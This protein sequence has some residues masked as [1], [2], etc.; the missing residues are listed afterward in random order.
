MKAMKMPELKAE[1]SKRGLPKS[2]KKMDL[3]QR[4]LQACGLAAAPAAVASPVPAVQTLKRKQEAGSGETPFGKR[5]K[6]I[7][8]EDEDS[9]AEEE[10]ASEEPSR[11]TGRNVQRK[12]Y[13]VDS[14]DD[15]E[16][17]ESDFSEEDDDD[18]SDFE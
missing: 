13:A 12:T 17:E 2:G 5:D 6:V 4:L 8:S 16:D 14:D 7:E 9:D 10:A 1:L 15:F 11:R 3:T 18:D